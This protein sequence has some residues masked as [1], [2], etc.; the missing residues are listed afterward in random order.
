MHG[1]RDGNVADWAADELE[2]K[3]TAPLF[4]AVGIFRPHLPWYVPKEFFDLYPLA[5]IQRPAVKANDLD[6]L[7]PLGRAAAGAHL[8]EQILAAGVWEKAIQGYLASIS[9]ADR[10]IGEVLDALDASGRAD[11]TIVVLWS[12]HGWHLGEKSHWRKY[13]LW[14]EATRVPLL[15]V[16]PGMT[17]PGSTCDRVVSL[18]DLYPTLVE[19][20]GLPPHEGISGASLVPLLRDPTTTW[21]RPA[22]TVAGANECAVRTERWRLIVYPDG[23]RELYDHDADPHEWTNLAGRQEWSAVEDELMR[24]IPST[25]APDTGRDP[26]KKAGDDDGGRGD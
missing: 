7:P 15:I 22:L 1:M 18:M 2:A 26:R 3:Q 8:H 17:E 10:C 9:F 19:L 24:S 20:C 23:T 12:D 11:H 25:C 16:A 4:L 13:V 6:D 21:D 14:E 5:G